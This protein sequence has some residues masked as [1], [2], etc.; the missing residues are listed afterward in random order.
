M[1]RLLTLVVALLWQPL[2]AQPA[3]KVVPDS[4]IKIV[5]RAERAD[6]TYHRGDKVVFNIA[7]TDSGKPAVGIVEWAILKDGLATDQKGVSE[8]VDGK[9]VASGSLNEPGFI[10]IRAVYRL[11]AKAKIAQVVGLGGAAIDPT[12]IKRSLPV[13]DD[14]DAFWDSMKKKLAAVPVE[15][16]LVSVKSPVK[17]VESFDVTAP[18]LGIQISGYMSKPVGAKPKSLPIILTVHG[19]GVSDSNLGGSAYWAARGLSPWI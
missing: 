5:A 2:I 18:A 16:K 4:P 17:D 3:K 7:V 10:Q 15:P 11:D 14:F 19:A 1:T 6:A 9:A 12:E 8:L 13:P